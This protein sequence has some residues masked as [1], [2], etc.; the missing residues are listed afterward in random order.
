MQ[1]LRGSRPLSVDYWD[2]HNFSAEPARW[3][4]GDWHH[5]VMGVQLTLDS[6]PVTVTW[7][8]TFHP[9]GVEV[10]SEPIERH[11]ALGEGGPQRIGPDDLARWEH[12]LDTPIENAAIMWDRFELGPV[13]LS[14]G[15]IVEPARAVDVPISLRLDFGA[16]PVWFVAAIPQPPDMKSVFV[17]GDEIMVVFSPEK[18]RDMGFEDPTLRA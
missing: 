8:N 2:I 13:R 14:D 17:G 4:Y 5:A 11:L 12:Y 16:G 15:A 18:M 9:Y 6:G 10:F 7:T 1:S 3:D